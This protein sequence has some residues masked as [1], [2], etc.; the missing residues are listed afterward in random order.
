MKRETKRMAFAAIAML[1]VAALVWPV[2]ALGAERSGT[3]QAGAT[4]GAY[5]TPDTSATSGAAGPG[6]AIGVSSSSTEEIIARLRE[7]VALALQRRALRF[8]NAAA[9]LERKQERLRTLCDQVESLGGDCERVR[10]MIQESERLLVQAREQ[11]RQA[12]QLFKG[13]PNAEHRRA[14]FVR[15]REQARLAVQTMQRSRLR[16]REAA[17][18]LRDV[19]EDLD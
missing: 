13:V 18:L 19:A 2:A 4:S 3:G 1:L 5:G 7:R 15:A 11:E 8:E 10:L 14:A 9:A 17:A 6:A 16:L 12:A